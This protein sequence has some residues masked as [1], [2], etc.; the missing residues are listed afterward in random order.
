MKSCY[1]EEKGEGDTENS[2][3]EVSAHQGGWRGGGHQEEEADSPG[4]FLRGVTVS[5]EATVSLTLLGISSEVLQL[6]KRQQCPSHCYSWGRGNSVLHT[7]TAPSSF[8][9]VFVSHPSPISSLH[10]ITPV[11]Q[12]T[13]GETLAE[14]GEVNHMTSKNEK[15]LSFSLGRR[16]VD[17][18]D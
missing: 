11:L 14:T 15:P 18:W 1:G 4:N 8:I 5:E 13:D 7:V 16:L 9:S 17:L 2:H 6:G 3:R 12:I 10:I